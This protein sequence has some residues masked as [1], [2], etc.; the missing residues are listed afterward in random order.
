MA[1]APEV[2][3]E[4]G[5]SFEEQLSILQNISKWRSME[6]DVYAGT[7]THGE[8]VDM[9]THQIRQAIKA[10]KTTDLEVLESKLRSMNENGL[11]EMVSEIIKGYLDENYGKPTAE[12]VGL[13]L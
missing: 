2:N 1:N 8:N 9:L 11:A 10:L 13:L 4:G 3:I 6:D 7:S 5:N 12:D